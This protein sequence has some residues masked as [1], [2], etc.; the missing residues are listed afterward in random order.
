MTIK[1][2]GRAA[3]GGA[4][5]RIVITTIQKFPFIIDG[6]AAWTQSIKDAL[7]NGLGNRLRP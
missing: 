4:R 3:R 2:L 6:K 7:D 5:Q 1:S